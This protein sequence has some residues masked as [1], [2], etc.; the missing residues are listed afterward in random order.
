MFSLS[1]SAIRA[2]SFTDFESLMNEFKGKGMINNIRLDR[3]MSLA[4]YYPKYNKYHDALYI[5]E[6]LITKN[7]NSAGLQNAI[8]DVYVMLKKNKKAKSY[9]KKAIALAKEQK[10]EKLV[11]YQNDLKRIN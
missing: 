1:R 6:Q 5:Y 4:S 11:E 9:Y 8:G 7:S 10:D 2:D 3:A